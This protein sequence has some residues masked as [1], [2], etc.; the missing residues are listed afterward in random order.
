MDETYK[1]VDIEKAIKNGNSLF[2]KSLPGFVIRLVKKIVHEDELNTTYSRHHNETGI[3]FVNGLLEDWKVKLNISGNENVPTEGRFIFVA[4]HPLGGMDALAFLSL[5]D[6][7]FHNVVSPSNQLFEYIPNLHSLILGINV[8][9]RNNKE[10]V[11]KLHL[12]FESDAQIMIFPAG[13]V[14]RR[15][16]GVIADPP[17]QKS[18]I[19][20][21]VQHRRDVIPV[22]ISGR[23]SNFFYR[24]ANLRTFLRIK[25]YI[26]T[27]LLPD[28]ML[29]QQNMTLNLR[30]GK[31]IPYQTFTNDKS[32]Y[33]WAQKVKEMVYQI[34][35]S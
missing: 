1:V 13:E 24:I 19:T 23:N 12:M 32:H 30:I 18:F 8:F 25:T 10:T 35:N 9:G 33:E 5:V 29:K 15:K 17:W 34:D 20:K 11:E 3:E 28:E 22:H 2:L 7:F 31:V 14:S 16:K 6:R 21:A 26:E 4:N 27:A